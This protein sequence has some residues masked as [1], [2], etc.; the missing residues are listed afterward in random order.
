MSAF[1]SLKRASNPLELEL[2]AIVNRGVLIPGTILGVSTRGV[3]TVKYGAI[4]PLTPS[5]NYFQPIL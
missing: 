5:P 3:H 1:G 2:Q 4:S